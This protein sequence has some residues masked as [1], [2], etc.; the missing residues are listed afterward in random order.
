MGQLNIALGTAYL[1]QLLDRYDQADWVVLAAYNAGPTSADRWLDRLGDLPPTQWIEGLS[2][3]ETRR[4]VRQ[5]LAF[6]VVY[7]WRLGEY[8]HRISAWLGE[9]TPPQHRTPLACTGSL[10][11]QS[12]ASP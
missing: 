2:F 3:N 7:S 11:G 6:A 5:V 1:R 12:I 10:P 9:S 4:Y 8:P